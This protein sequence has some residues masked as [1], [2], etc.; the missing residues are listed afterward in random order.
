MISLF[1]VENV[2]KFSVIVQRSL[3]KIASRFSE[4]KLVLCK[5]LPKLRSYLKLGL[6]YIYGISNKT[7]TCFSVKIPVEWDINQPSRWNLL[8]DTAWRRYMQKNM[9]FWETGMS[10]WR[11]E[12]I[13]KKADLHSLGP[14]V[15]KM[16]DLHWLTL[17]HCIGT[18]LG[19]MC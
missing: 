4:I 17:R 10:S 6:F 18:R 9:W 19:T 2:V 14:W 13:E 11:N 12:K 16:E 15:V 7:R 3:R 8:W 1:I 5:K